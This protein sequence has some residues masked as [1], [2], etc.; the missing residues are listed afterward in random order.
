MSISVLSRFIESFTPFPNIPI[1]KF[2]NRRETGNLYFF[3][4]RPLHEFQ[5]SFRSWSPER[6]RADQ[7]EGDEGDGIWT[8]GPRTESARRRCGSNF[9][10]PRG[11]G[12]PH[13]RGGGFL[14]KLLGRMM[15]ELPQGVVDDGGLG[16][17]GRSRGQGR[18]WF[19]FH[20]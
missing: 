18:R 7:E 3:D 4:S 17:S 2:P 1:G 12:L 15:Q 11:L 5:Y 20:R 8:Q 9:G 13:R 16:G 6:L 14:S 19:L 10:L